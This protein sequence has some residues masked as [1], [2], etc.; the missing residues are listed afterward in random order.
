MVAGAGDSARAAV[1]TGTGGSAA[2]LEEDLAGLERAYRALRERMRQQSPRLAR[3]LTSEPTSLT[4]LQRLLA[5]DGSEA[6]AY[7]VLESQVIVWHIGP[8]A[9]HV[10]SVF[11]PRSELKRKV[12]SL[13]DGLVDPE[14]SFDQSL[15]HQLYLFLVAPVLEWIESERLVIIPHE[16]LHYLPFQTLITDIESGR[17]LGEQYAI[18]YAPSATVLAALPA[19]EPLRAERLLA[20]ADPGLKHAPGEVRAIAAQFPDAAETRLQ[21]DALPTVTELNAWLPR[22]DL[23]HLAV[24][25]RFVSDQPLLSHLQ[26]A[27]SASED[28]RL[29][30]AEM[31]GLP[32]D[33]AKLVVLSACETGTV[34]AT[35]ANEVLGMTRGL[36]FA[37]ADALL[38]SAWAIDDEAT[39]AW[40]RTFYDAAASMPLGA[41]SREAIQQI[42]G[43]PAY[44]HPY[45]WGA[46]L[47]IGR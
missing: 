13:R 24:H 27:A 14:R 23:V 8:D 19:P 37:G 34:R 32:L 29:T 43:N 4:D 5:A 10:R 39:A 36:L 42:H 6:L 44:A 12:A 33:A 40:M 20:V 31:Y 18:T 28:G 26:L 16:D 3:L 22:K 9:V 35:H 17:Y 15:A 41:A 25:G 45:Y 38:L 47:A 30:A 21:T 46:F 7:L 2:R 1:L 11:L